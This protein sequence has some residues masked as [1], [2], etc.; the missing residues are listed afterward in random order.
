VI[1]L[2][3]VAVSLSSRQIVRDVSFKAKPGTVT[4]IVGPNGSGKTTLLR[5]ITGEVAYS[6]STTINGHE[7]AKL[8]PKDQAKRRGVL[9]QSSH[10][11]FPFTVLEVVG[12]GREHQVRNSAGKQSMEDALSE[13]GLGGFGPRIYNELSGG[14][15]QRAQLARVLFQVSTAKKDDE[16]KWLLLD[17]PVSSLDIRHQLL[18]MKKATDFAAL[19]GGVIAIMH[20]LNL[21]SMFADQVCM[22]RRGQIMAAGSPKESF[23]NANV[24]RVFEC[25]LKVSALPSSSVP[26][27]LPQ[28][29]NL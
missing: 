9:P 5:A 17:E 1:S 25:N 4:A 12:L 6:G 19:G 22:L 28:S 26:F 20:D 21:T 27:V 3:S 7:V 29:V 23:T 13:V 18:I 8:S 24:Q 16:P 14:E 10:V 15:Q 11:A 2:T